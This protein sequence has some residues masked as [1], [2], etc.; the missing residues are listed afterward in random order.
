MSH[1]HGRSSTE[2]RLNLGANYSPGTMKT[3]ESESGLAL[4]ARLGTRPSLK[5]IDSHFFPAGLDPCDIVEISGNRGS[6]KSSFISH[7]ILNSL[8]PEAWCGLK[9]G[10]SSCGVVYIDA[11][12][13]FSILQMENMLQRRIKK[14]VKS[15]RA[16]LKGLGGRKTAGSLIC[17]PKTFQ[18][19]LHSG[20]RQQESEINKLTRDCL[21]HL[22]YLKCTDSFQFT[23]TLLSLDELAQNRDNISLIVIDSI[24]AFYWYDRT[25]KAGTWYKLEQHYNRIFK[26][27]LGHIRKHKLVL[28]TSRQALFQKRPLKEERKTSYQNEDEEGDFDA[29]DYEYLGR[30]WASGVTHRIYL[31]VDTL[32]ETSNTNLPQEQQVQDVQGSVCQS[33]E[34][35]SIM[36]KSTQERTTYLA[37]VNGKNN[38]KN[39]VTFT[40]HE[41]G[42]RHLVVKD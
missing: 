16:E 29:T 34:S 13:H 7:L 22:L 9:L 11:D 41:D 23:I 28:L 31:S 33:E 35:F 3:P 6:G 24:S 21:K 42:I 25:Y 20:K 15:A 39:K 4:L 36:D 10:G 19:F 37:E 27:F 5:N 38:M 1:M 2:N 30:E 12:L 17:S 18:D 14:M 40:I 32:G 26:T 8:M